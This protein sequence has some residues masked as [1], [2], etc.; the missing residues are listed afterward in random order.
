LPETE[1][2]RERRIS[3]ILNQ[4]SVFE[5]VFQL[6]QY[7]ELLCQ[8]E[9]SAVKLANDGLLGAF[10]A[11]MGHC[12]Y[13]SGFL[14]QGIQSE[15]RAVEL[16][17]AA[18]NLEEA[19]FA[20]HCL[21]WAHCLKGNL[22]LA[23]KM[24][25]EMSKRMDDRFS[26]SRHAYVSAYVFGLVCASWTCSLLGR[27]DE[28]LEL[29]H[30]ITRI[31]Q[32]RSDN[33]LICWGTCAESATYLCKGDLARATK[34]GELAVQE[35][36]TPLEM[37]FTQVFFEWTRCRA[38]DPSRAIETMSGLL[39]MART[40]RQDAPAL[41]IAA[42]LSEAYLV[43]QRYSE[44][45]QSADEY[46]RLAERFGTKWLFAFY[47]RLLGEI[48]LKTRPQGAKPHFDKAI[49][50]FQE[51]KAEP[52]LALAYSGVVRLHKLQ[53]RPEE[54]REY[55]TKALEIFERLGTLIEPD[56]V[57]RELAELPAPA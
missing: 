34:S 6:H 37:T 45:R 15:N 25:E 21:G 13:V 56:K 29:A 5:E 30:K 49:S 10:Y 52:E 19:A 53:G 54:A 51:T 26:G 16:S 7:Y 55:L 36:L 11:R 42:V 27:W 31:G 23:L 14:E 12:Q 3:L 48:S 33:S 40:A 32:G 38:G 28:A 46:M 9:Q 57:R 35:A 44:A 1:E 43:A 24:E 4:I 41:I 2:S 20:Y 18:G 50:V 47:H 17:E 8:Y 39:Q 22:E